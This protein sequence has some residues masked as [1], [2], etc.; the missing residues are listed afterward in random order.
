MGYVVLA[1]GY[2]IAVSLGLG[3][4]V[5]L[6]PDAMQSFPDALRTL[7]GSGLVTGG[8]TALVLNAVLPERE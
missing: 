7:F 3:L 5:E 2:S 6:R 1:Y 4:G 8:L